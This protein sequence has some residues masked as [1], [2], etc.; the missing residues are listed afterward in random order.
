MSLRDKLA[1][2][3]VGVTGDPAAWSSTHVGGIFVG[4]WT[5]LSMSDGFGELSNA[6]GPLPLAV[7]VRRAA[8]CVS[9]IIGPNRPPGCWPRPF[10]PRVHDVA[11]EGRAMKSLGVTVDF[12]PVVDVSGQPDDDDR[13][14]VLQRRSPEV[15]VRMVPMP[16]GA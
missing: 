2:L 8:R 10:P 7:S 14:P 9:G 1:Q 13:R 5:D 4:S 16:G 15:A 6:G 12:A 3:V 11:F